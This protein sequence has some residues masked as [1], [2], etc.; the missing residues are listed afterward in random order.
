MAMN[1]NDE[2]LYVSVFGIPNIK[3]KSVLKVEDDILIHLSIL[4]LPGLGH[5]RKNS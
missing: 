2:K 4:F 3:L 1:Q 5:Q